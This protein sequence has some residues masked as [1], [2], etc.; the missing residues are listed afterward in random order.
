MTEMKKSLTIYGWLSFLA[1][2]STIALKSYAY[3]PTD[4]VGLLSDAMESLINLAAAVIMLAVF[5]IGVLPGNVC[6]LVMWL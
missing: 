5:S 2:I 1:A 4:S 6:G 3:W